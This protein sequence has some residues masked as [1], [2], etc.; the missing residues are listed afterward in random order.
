MD[1]H[2]KNIVL[3]GASGGIGVKTAQQLAHEGANII[4]VGRNETTLNKVLESLLSNG[5]THKVVV[6]DLITAAG[7][8]TVVAAASQADAL[9]NAAGINQLSLLS[10]MTDQQVIDIISSNLTVPMLLSKKILPILESRSEAAL[11]NIGSILGSI[12]MP[13]SVAYCA[14]K[15]GL[16]GFTESLRRELA[17]SNI[18]ISYIAPRVTETAMNNDAASGLNRELGNSVDKPEQIANIIVDTLKRSKSSQKY[19]GWPEK[20]FVRINAILPSVVDGSLIR[21]LPIIKKY[22]T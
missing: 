13:G 22:T 15:F 6:A 16:R 10:Q 3:T 8:E 9:I 19:V 12:G 21:Q 4:L 20:L 7:R 17:D 18:N 5:Q 1:L 14:S 2:N 11:I